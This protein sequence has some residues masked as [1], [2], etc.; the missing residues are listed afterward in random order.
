MADLLE[1]VDYT[2]EL[3]IIRDYKPKTKIVFMQNDKDSAKLLFSFTK[4]GKPID[5]SGVT[6]VLMAVKKPD[7]TLV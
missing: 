5:M 6:G 3:D 2:V 7:G 4:L 1:F